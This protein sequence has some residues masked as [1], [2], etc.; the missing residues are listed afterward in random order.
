MM[1]VAPP[2]MR[3]ASAALTELLTG[4]KE[5]QFVSASAK[6]NKKAD[7]DQALSNSESEQEK[8]AAA[9]PL[10]C[11]RRAAARKDDTANETDNAKVSPGVGDKRATNDDDNTAEWFLSLMQNN[12]KRCDGDDE[13]EDDDANA[14]KKQKRLLQ[15]APTSISPPP[16]VGG[17]TRCECS[18]LVALESAWFHLEPPMKRKP[19][20]KVFKASKSFP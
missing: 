7:G 1:D 6:S 12:A 4:R 18:C 9:S 10:K 13:D 16:A 20:L 19:G 11:T 5:V 3:H 2:A 15:S 17:C 14:E 8:A